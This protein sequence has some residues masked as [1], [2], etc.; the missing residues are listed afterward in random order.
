MK[1][2]LRAVAGAY[3]FDGWAGRHR[4]ADDPNEPWART[5][6]THLT[7]RLAGEFSEREPLWGWR[8]D[9]VDIMERQIDLAADHGLAFFAFCWY[10]HKD[11]A[12]VRQDPK[13]TGLEL[14][15]R[16][17]NRDRMRFCLLV[18]NHGGFVLD[19]ADDWE[20]AA[21]IWL[22]YLT[23]E[24]H[25][26][27][28]GKPLVIIFEPGGG[29][30]EGFDRVQKTARDAGLM[31]VAMAG[32]RRPPGGMGYTH[33]T[34]YACAPGW[35]R[36][37]GRHS[38]AE[39]AAIAEE[40]WAGSAARPHIPLVMSGW[41]SRPW[42][43]PA[44]RPAKL[45]GWYFPDRSPERFGEHVRAALRWM[46]EHPG[47]TTGERLLVIYAWN[48]FGEGGYLAPTKGDPEAR[49]LQALR[50][51]LTSGA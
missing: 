47:D 10:W 1:K 32:C 37:S 29:S 45:L 17:R 25:V 28:G 3:Y 4:L 5:A 41:D 35:G 48:E 21:G 51:A 38:Y 6:P 14:F 7:R 13:H 26:R 44:D 15:L 19:G 18:A 16:A 40:R 20:K 36:E 30:R 50:S 34:D 49:Y 2:E 31:G 46:D 22:P 8:D 43:E 12:E 23:H 9:S 27:V 24:R 33:S 42:E 11:P 39:L